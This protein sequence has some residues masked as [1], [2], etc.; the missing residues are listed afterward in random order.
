MVRTLY[1][2]FQSFEPNEEFWMEK[3]ENWARGEILETA[4][5]S[6]CNSETADHGPAFGNLRAMAEVLKGS[7]EGKNL[8]KESFVVEI[9]QKDDS[10]PVLSAI[11]YSTDVLK[12]YAVR[13][14]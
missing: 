13:I 1:T 14:R 3:Q 11:F 9:D 10:P 4:H 2:I 12:R 7:C 8:K 6:K 5:T